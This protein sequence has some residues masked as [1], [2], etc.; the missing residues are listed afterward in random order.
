[1]VNIIFL[2]SNAPLYATRCVGQSLG[3]FGAVPEGI[4]LTQKLLCRK[5]ISFDDCIYG[6]RHTF[7]EYFQQADNYILPAVNASNQSLNLKS[8]GTERL[9][10]VPVL[11]GF[12]CYMILDQ[13]YWWS[14]REDYSFGFLVPL[15][16]GYVLY[17]RW[18]SIMGYFFREGTEPLPTRTELWT[19][20]FEWIAFA[21]FLG[22][23]GLFAIGALL[24]SV[25]GPQNPASLAIAVGF[26]GLLLSTVFILSRQSTDDEMIS[27]KDRLSFT[28]LF[29]F[30]ALAWLISAP[31]VSALEMRIRVFLL[32]KV[33]F[34][35]FTLFDLLGLQI[36]REGNVLFLPEGRVGVEEACSG[37]YS[38]TACIFVGSFLAAVFLD[39]FWKKILLVM[40]AMLL[41]VLTNLFRS[42]FLTSWAYFYGPSA[43]NDSWS[44]PL[45]GEI[46]T[47]HDVMGLA[48]LG[49]TSVCLLLLLPVFNFKLTPVRKVPAQGMDVETKQ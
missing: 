11:L 22:G 16:T 4:A 38:L 19:Q 23:I 21:V 26:S 37:I 2:Q 45:I 27:L 44:L 28:G 13:Y 31:L 43:I 32:N 42:L 33:T 24:R 1:M 25:T 10:A 14:T 17:E 39:R 49:I 18:P 48:V 20:L 47:V 34:V 9:L 6:I 36:D 5:I 15:F 8:I 46:G 12:L 29:L 30:P 41:A 3:P 7:N 35:V 40:T